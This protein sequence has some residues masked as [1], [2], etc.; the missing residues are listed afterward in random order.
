MLAVAF[1]VR[2]LRIP[3]PEADDEDR[4]GVFLVAVAEYAEAGSLRMARRFLRNLEIAV[5]RRR[6]RAFLD[7]LEEKQRHGKG[8]L[9]DD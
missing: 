3:V 1:R 7:R 6:T 2:L 5:A 9:D 4:W 8:V